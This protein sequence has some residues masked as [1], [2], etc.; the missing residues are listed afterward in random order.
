M[1]PSCLTGPI[2]NILFNHKQ[3]TISNSVRRRQ[4]EESFVEEV[5]TSSTLLE[6]FLNKGH[7]ERYIAYIGIVV[8]V[9]TQMNGSSEELKTCSVIFLVAISAVYELES[10]AMSHKYDIHQAKWKVIIFGIAFN[11]AR[12][13]CFYLLLCILKPQWFTWCGFVIVCIIATTYTYSDELK[14]KFTWCYEKGVLVI[15]YVI[16]KVLKLI[17]KDQASP[18][19]VP[20]RATV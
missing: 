7:F 4:D 18:A 16:D 14:T 6:R 9:V 19:S 20:T 15:N 12:L 1:N 5:D 13:L 2:N 8:A 17:R 10:W 11:F 3:L